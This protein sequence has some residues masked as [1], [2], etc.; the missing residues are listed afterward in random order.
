[1][2]FTDDSKGR[3]VPVL[4]CIILVVPSPAFV[5]GN[6]VE[7]LLRRPRRYR[8]VTES[9]S[10]LKA[11]QIRKVAS[12][13]H[14][15]VYKI[16]KACWWLK[17]NEYEIHMMW[18]PSHL[19]VRGNEQTDQLAGDALKNSIEWHAPSDF[20]PLSR[21]R[22]LEGWQSGWYTYFICLVVSFML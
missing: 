9:S 7:C 3:R 13:T 2:F 15:L 19:G 1:M 4:V 6:Q 8:I 18:I 12:R 17:N 11:L 5:L 16:K 22:L 10:S 20:L 21:I 14:S